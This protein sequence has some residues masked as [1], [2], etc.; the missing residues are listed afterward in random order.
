MSQQEAIVHRLRELILNGTLGPGQRLIETSLA[1]AL[2]V[3]RTPVRRAIQILENEGLA[4]SHGARGY[5][6]REFSY[7]DM[8]HAIEVRG[9]LEGLA[10]RTVA[11]R[12]MDAA[13]RQCLEASLEAGRALLAKGYLTQSDRQAFAELNTGFHDALVGAAG[14]KAVSN[15]LAI[16]D[17][18]PF[19]S[20]GAIAI[21]IDGADTR[22]RQFDLLSQAQSQHLN[23]YQ[24]LVA[25]QAARAEA[26][27]REHAYLAVENVRLVMGS[28]EAAML[29]PL[30]NANGRG[31]S[32]REALDGGVAA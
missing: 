3:S 8:L 20:A 32:L 1:Q 2:G 30:A 4:I 11:A 12:G 7:R 24:A 28:G 13:T 18:L 10:A 31:G 14:I 17:H 6:V 26:L 19:A 25:G 27:M 5:A 21:D 9:A 15:A 23:L 29:E 22:Q 16:N